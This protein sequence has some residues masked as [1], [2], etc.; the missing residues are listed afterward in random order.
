MKSMNNATREIKP[1]A[2]LDELAEILRFV[3]T[4]F[5]QG[6]YLQNSASKRVSAEFSRKQ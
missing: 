5:Q 2:L 1:Q 3:Q 4:T 6:R